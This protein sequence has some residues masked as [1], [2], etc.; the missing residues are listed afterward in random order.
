MVKVCAGKILL[1]LL[2][3]F[4]VSYQAFAQDN[5]ATRE[6]LVQE[7]DR[8]VLQEK[9]TSPPSDRKSTYDLEEDQ[10]QSQMN[11]I[12]GEEEI[13]YIIVQGD[14]LS[15]SFFNGKKREKSIYQVSGSGEIYLPVVGAV[16]VLKLNRK[17][18]RERISAVLGEYI[19]NPEVEIG[20]NIE[21]QV[22][23]L[24][25]VIYPGVYGL[26]ARRFTVMEVLARA[27]GPI[28]ERATL[29]SVLLIRGPVDN[30]T[31][32]R[33]N[34]KKMLTKGDMSDN[35]LVK[36]GDLVY[37]PQS[38]ISNV[39]VFFNNIYKYVL[40]WYGFGGQDIIEGGRA[41]LDS[42]KPLKE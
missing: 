28:K 17:Q 22:A 12:T 26:P 41:L 2:C 29:R 42:V 35:L 20:I 5:S 34:L 36:P 13:R 18:A 16:K 19:R 3:S 32:L 10:I 38:F 8:G 25:E 27:S 4:C 21:G 23:I 40:K 31:I 7:M 6:F 15:I 33:L 30:P 9:V 11:I 39:D 1:M 24:G 37:V 14:M